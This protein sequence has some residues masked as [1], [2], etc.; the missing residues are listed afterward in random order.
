MARHR[1]FGPLLRDARAGKGVTLG[2]LAAELGVSVPFLSDVELGRRAALSNERIL[3]A[4][5]ALGIVPTDL[6]AAAAAARGSFE[7][8]DLGDR[9]RQEVAARLASIWAELSEEQLLELKV[10]LSSW[11]A[12]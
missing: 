7:L 2:A 11:K 4:A 3:A 12:G 6:L 1:P 8:R 5:K 10:L 9:L